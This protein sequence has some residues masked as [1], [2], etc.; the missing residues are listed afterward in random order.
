MP[1]AAVIPALIVYT[2]VADVKKLV[3]GFKMELF[4]FV[5]SVRVCWLVVCFSAVGCFKIPVGK[6][7]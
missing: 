2:N 3:V 7:R 4:V 5:L 1:A 6:R